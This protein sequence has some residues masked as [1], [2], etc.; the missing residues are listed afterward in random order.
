MRGCVFWGVWLSGLI[1]MIGAM[2]TNSGKYYMGIARGIF[3]GLIIQMIMETVE[4]KENG[5]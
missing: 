3:I 1:T 4:T 2:I 5:N